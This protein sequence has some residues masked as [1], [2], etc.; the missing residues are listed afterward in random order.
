MGNTASKLIRPGPTPAQ[1]PRGLESH[2]ERPVQRMVLRQHLHQAVP[3]G[4]AHGARLPSRRS[5]II[6]PRPEHRRNRQIQPQLEQPVRCG[7]WKHFRGREVREE[8]AGGGRSAGTRPRCRGSRRIERLL[9]PAAA[10]ATVR[11]RRIPT[12]GRK[13]VHTRRRTRK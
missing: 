11:R 12:A 6:H 9:H 1:S 2:L 8:V 13:H 4:Q 7:R 3:M 10:T 5:S